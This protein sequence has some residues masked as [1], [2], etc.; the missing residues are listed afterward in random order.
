MGVR[1]LRQDQH[2]LIV[3]KPSSIHGTGGFARRD[4]RRG[5]R[6]IE[7][8]GP[9]LTKAEAQAELGKQNVYIFILDDDHDIDGS[10]DWN[11]ARFIN[12]S[13][14]PNCEVEIVRG[15][16]W[17]AARRDIEAGEE[18]TYNYSHDL[19]NYEERPCYCGAL[20]CVGYMV[21]EE[22]FNT[23]RQRQPS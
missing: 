16:I 21:A 2:P 20:N 5:K 13:C 15:R 23:L 18:L 3:F 1:K 14:D 4:I 8:V 9:K 10:V 7:Y 11:A 22:F 17:I 6:I 19:E 12:H